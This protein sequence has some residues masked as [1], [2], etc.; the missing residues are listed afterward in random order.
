MSTQALNTVW[1]GRL[2]LQAAALALLAV[3]AASAHSMAQQR[4]SDRQNRVMP[5]DGAAAGLDD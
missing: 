3:A 5:T 4:A 2:A 1:R